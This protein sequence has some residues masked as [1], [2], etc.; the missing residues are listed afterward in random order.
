MML[1]TCYVYEGSTWNG[2]ATADTKSHCADINF[3]AGHKAFPACSGPLAMSA[4][5]E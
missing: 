5:L 2:Y 1:Q 3:V 4:E